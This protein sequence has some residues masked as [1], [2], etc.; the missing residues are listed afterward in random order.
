M[1]FVVALGATLLHLTLQ[2][3]ARA[4]EWPTSSSAEHSCIVTA[5]DAVNAVPNAVLIDTRT[6]AAK[7]SAWIPGSLR[8]VPNAISSNALVR[9]SKSAILIGDAKNV[10]ALIAQC[11]SLHRVGLEQIRVLIGG[12]AAWSRAGGAITGTI[13]TRDAQWIEPL[14]LHALLGSSSTVVTWIGAMPA[15]VA[16]ARAHVVAMPTATS[17]AQAMSRIANVS[18][19]A[20]GPIVGVIAFADKTDLSPWRKTLAEVGA[21]APLFY[22]DTDRRYARFM[23]QQKLIAEYANKPPQ[24]RCDLPR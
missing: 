2:I 7:V 11:E 12:L 13:D 14:D 6:G 17:P 20:R 3:G 8:I 24:P 9:H 5:N 16:N 21:D 15:E 23:T 18:K 19:T 4:A 1:K 10:P 22:A